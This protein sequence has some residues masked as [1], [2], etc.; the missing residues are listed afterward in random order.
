MRGSLSRR[1][2]FQFAGS[3]AASLALVHQ[4]VLAETPDLLGASQAQPGI[5]PNTIKRRGTGLRG[6][7]PQRVSPGYTLFAPLTG[8]GRVV[9][10][11]INGAVTHTWSMPYPPGLYGYLTDTGTPFYNGKIPKDTFMGKRAFQGGAALEVDWNGKVLWEIKQP[12]HHH[13]G[14]LLRNGNVL[15]LCATALPVDVAQ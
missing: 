2:W 15:L 6:Y 11:D 10:I 13:D 14:R 12:D 7:D 1:E 4:P 8:G 3:T 5:E 9:L